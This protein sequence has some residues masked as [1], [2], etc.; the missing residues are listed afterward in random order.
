MVCGT[1]IPSLD[2]LG[3]PWFA[4][5]MVNLFGSAAAAANRWAELVGAVHN[6]PKGGVTMHIAIATIGN[7]LGV[8]ATLAGFSPS[9]D[10]V[11]NFK[12]NGR[13]ITISGRCTGLLTINSD[14][15]W[16]CELGDECPLVNRTDF[17]NVRAGHRRIDN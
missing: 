9:A 5:R 2:D 8:E 12:F 10:E 17:I 14:G 15:T 1:K 11:E 7:Y 3:N 6:T 13:L 16:S 4:R